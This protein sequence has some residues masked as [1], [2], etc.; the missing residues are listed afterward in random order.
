MTVL[1][2]ELVGG[3]RDGERMVLRPG[4]CELQLACPAP[5]RVANYGADESLVPVLP[6]GV[7][8]PD[9]EADVLLGRWIWHPS[10][11]SR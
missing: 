9:T 6:V 2:V 4:L 11:V 1:R 5:H 8:A 3:P 10:E 7:Y